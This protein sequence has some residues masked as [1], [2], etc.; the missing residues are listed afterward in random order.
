[1]VDTKMFATLLDDCSY[2]LLVHNYQYI[3]ISVQR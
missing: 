2:L 1:L 3:V